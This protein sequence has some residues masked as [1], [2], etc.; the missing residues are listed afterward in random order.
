MQKDERRTGALVLVWSGTVGNDPL[1]FI[2]R[3]IGQVSFD[4]A[5]RNRNRSGHV[6]CLKSPWIAYIYDDRRAAFQS[7]PGLFQRDAR[8]VRV[9]QRQLSFF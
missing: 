4:D 8:H 5:Q 1:V 7:C 6:T 2:E 9:C 3:H